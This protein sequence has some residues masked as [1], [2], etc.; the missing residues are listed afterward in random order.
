[1]RQHPCCRTA[2]R[3]PT[4]TVTPSYG[5]AHTYLMVASR[6]RGDVDG[7]R[8]AVGPVTERAHEASLPEYEA[9]ALANRA[10]L[11]GAQEKKTRRP[12]T[13]WPT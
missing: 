9:M 11:R 10:W 12:P 5:Q 3:T 1:M 7:V 13:R 8:K 2:S 4:S 6:E